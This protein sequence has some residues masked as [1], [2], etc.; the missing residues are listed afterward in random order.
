[1]GV[2]RFK[3]FEID[4]TACAMKI[5]TDGVL[6]GA[7]TKMPDDTQVIDVGCGSGLIC[8]MLAQRYP[9]ASI[10]GIE[11]DNDAAEAAERNVEASPWND[12]V[13][14]IAGD[15]LAM[16]CSVTIS[17]ERP[18]C[19]V[20]NPPFFTETLRSPQRERALAR[21][22]EGLN[23][24][25]LIDLFV[26]NQNLHSDASG[27]SLTFI[28]PASSFDEIMFS[29]SLRR[30]A[31]KRICFVRSTLRKPPSRVLFEVICDREMAATTERDELCL[32]NADGSWSN[33]YR[34]LTRD[35]YL[36][37]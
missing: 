34:E 11:I 12:R 36:S 35:Y 28:A 14:I 9:Q 19:I 1:M 5:G 22:G 29:L 37:F 2:F 26:S 10:T 20:S 8:L 32:R 6:V 18:L 31:A 4:D 16:A 3:Q 23:P 30:L 15:A 17:T 13:R 27:D 24:N 25:S 7:W 33:A 21:H